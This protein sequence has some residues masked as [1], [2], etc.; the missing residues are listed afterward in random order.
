[1]AVVPSGEHD[2]RIPDNRETVT[3][4]IPTSMFTISLFG[5]ELTVDVKPASALLAV[6]GLYVL[7][8]VLTV[9][10]IFRVR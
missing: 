9:V 1:M 4:W 10:K 2:S 8:R 5:R 3:T 7:R 6:L